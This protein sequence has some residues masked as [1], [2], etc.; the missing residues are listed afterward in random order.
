MATT[1]LNSGPLIIGGTGGSGT[2]AIAKCLISSKQV[3]LGQNHN[4]ALDCLDFKGLYDHYIPQFLPNFYSGLV[5]PLNGFSELASFETSLRKC[6]DLYMEKYAQPDFNKVWGWKGPRS[7][8]LLPMFHYFLPNLKFLHVVRD[9]RDM[10]YSN[11]QNQLQLYGDLSLEGEDLGL[12]QSVRSIVL[13]EKVN[14]TV[15]SYALTHIKE[16]YLCIKYEDLIFHRDKT[17]VKI[18]KFLEIDNAYL[19]D[20]RSII[21]PSPTLG[22]WREQDQ[23]ELQNVVEKGSRGLYY[24]GYQ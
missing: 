18:A 7:M 13:W 5:S 11:N 4:R 12:A 3:Y 9:G 2:R 24:F 15:S 20:S 21:S 22:R 1:L 16:N 23:K 10:A 14:M 17:L 8:Y 6:V 19:L